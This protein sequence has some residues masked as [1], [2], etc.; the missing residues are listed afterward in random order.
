MSKERSKTQPAAGSVKMS[1]KTLREQVERSRLIAE[2]STYQALTGSGWGTPTL[3]ELGYPGPDSSSASP[4]RWRA[5]R[6][7]SRV[8]PERRRLLGHVSECR[9][10]YRHNPT[11]RTSSK[12]HVLHRRRR[13]RLQGDA[14]EP[15]DAA[16]KT[17]AEEVQKWIDEYHR[18]HEETAVDE[19]ESVRRGERDGR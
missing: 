8:L 11:R 7:R 6:P 1:L 9:Y 18:E 2:A 4:T 19:Q 13:V 5:T 16:S 17:A 14:E 10:L 3:A 12:P 15:D